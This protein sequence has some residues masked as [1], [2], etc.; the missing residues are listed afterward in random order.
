MPDMFWQ[1]IQ[2]S[3]LNHYF[4]NVKNAENH[5][6]EIAI[7]RTATLF[8][9][10]YF[11]KY[12][13]LKFIIRAGT[14]IENIDTKF[15][16]RK[17]VQVFNTPD[18]NALSAAEHTVSL[19]LALVKRHREAI[20]SVLEGE[21]KRN[22]CESWEISDLKILI[23]GVGR[24][25]TKVA[26]IMQY[27]G[28]EVKGVDP[29]LNEREWQEKSVEPVAYQCGLTWAN[30]ITY[31]C[32]LTEETHHYFNEHIFNVLNKKIWLVNTSRG[33]VIQESA[34]EEGLL[35]GK[36]LGVALDVFSEEPW[37]VKTF[38]YDPRVIITPHIGAY[39]ERAKERMSYETFLVWQKIVK[40]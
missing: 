5:K 22:L 26:N 21:W 30:L 1:L 24:I 38:G 25:G 12:P 2:K 29:Y 36:I 4:Y 39:T 11:D 35:S 15:A 40:Y 9:R 34:I 32:P 20:R 31:H 28:A 19:I 27:L 13:N 18:A 23:V 10:E 33:D 3:C 16:A 37:K 6:V 8:T 14:G 17:N 7:I